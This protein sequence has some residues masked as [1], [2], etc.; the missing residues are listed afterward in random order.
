MTEIR[1]AANSTG[2]ECTYICTYIHDHLQWSLC[3][4][5]TVE[6]MQ[7]MSTYTLD[8]PFERSLYTGLIIKNMQHTH[9]Q[10]YVHTDAL[11]TP[12]SNHG[13]PMGDCLH[14]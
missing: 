14:H 1:M 9:T 13:T 4:G 8:D 5:F 10:A 7:Y 2:I 11:N 6:N 12:H 3:T